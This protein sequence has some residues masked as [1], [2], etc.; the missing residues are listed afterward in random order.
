MKRKVPIIIYLEKGIGNTT[1]L[2]HSLSPLLCLNHIW[3]DIKYWVQNH[4]ST[5]DDILC[6]KDHI[7]QLLESKNPHEFEENY[8]AFSFKCG[9][10]FLEYFQTQKDEIMTSA[11]RYNT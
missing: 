6:S 4:N 10:G 9:K 11:T 7:L 2:I 5:S 8:V 1:K 3:Q